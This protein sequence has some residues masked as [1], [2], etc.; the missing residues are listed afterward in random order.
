MKKIL[1]I[2]SLFIAMGSSAFAA[3]L[4]SPEPAPPAATE[5]PVVNYGWDGPYVGVMG[6]AGW[7][8]NSYDAAGFPS[9]RNYNGGVLGAF[10][11]WNRQLDNNIVFGLEGDFG[12]NWNKGHVNGLESGTD[13]S[14][15]VRARAGY[16][17]DNALLYGAAGWT[18]TRGYLENATGGNDHK[19]FNGYTVGAGVDYKFTDNMF[20]RAE[21]RFNDYGSRSINGVDI[22]PRQHELLLGVGMKF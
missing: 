2:S 21:Y 16:A 10:A 5:Q 7:L 11:G 13:W 22:N 1:A 17:M 18:V 20:G 6:G 19:A 3:D 14:G 9:G 15:S 4:V 12:Y 8:H